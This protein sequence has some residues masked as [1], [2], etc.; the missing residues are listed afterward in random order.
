MKKNILFFL[1]VFIYGGAGSAITRMCKKFDKSKYNFYIIS[2]G[3]CSYKNQLKKYVKK[4]YE[5]KTTRAIYSIFEI[6]KII[7]QLNQQNNAIF[8]SNIHYANIITILALRNYS[9]LKIILV[10]RTALEELN[11]YFNLKDFIKKKIIKLLIKFY[12]KSANK[13]ITNSKKASN[14]L[15]IL[16]NSNV[17]TIYSPAFEKFVKKIKKNNFPKRI[18]S[19]GR[20]SREKGYDTLIKAINLINNKSF[21]LEIVGEGD[22]RKKLTKLIEQNKLKDQIFLRGHKKDPSKYFK[23]ADLYINCSLFEGF[24]NSVVEAISYNIPVICSRSHGGIN[25][26][27][28]NGK[29]GHFFKSGNSLELANLISK[30]LKEEKKFQKKT[31]EA[32]NNIS[33]YN[34]NSCVREYQKIFENL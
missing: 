5:L 17:K 18:L 2:I 33:K 29:G 3:P 16:S 14:D 13:I 6:R 34:I 10:E 28:L 24:P 30:F 19:V 32:K 4:F 7:N 15:K 11:I 26:I 9:N 23:K 12:Y 21:I 25:E 27:L 31:K 8:V 20:L 22:Q 1:P